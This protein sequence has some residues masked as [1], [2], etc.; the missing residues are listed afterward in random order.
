MS[1]RLST[2]RWSRA[3]AQGTVRAKEQLSTFRRLIACD[4]S[5]S[6]ILEFAFTMP[7]FVL[8]ALTALELVNLALAHMT[9]SQVAMSVADNL[10]R[11]KTS[12]P[13]GLPRLREV[14]IN[15]T[16]IGAGAQ[17]SEGFDLLKNGR[18]VVSSLQRN[19]SG[20]QTIAW[21]RC[22]GKL[23]VTSQYG[24]QGATQPNSGTAGFQGMGRASDRVQ[25]EP[26]S[27]IIFAEVTYDYQ[28]LIGSWLV[29]TFRLRKEAAFYVRDDR[30]LVGGT[31]ANGMYNP[32]PTATVSACNVFNDTF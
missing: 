23:A 1:K 9:A 21:Q 10:S 31:A 30:D 24:V 3:V 16:M 7:I 12:V 15:D 4:Q 2:A 27:A 18:I 20:R 17:G 6:V 29:G 13:L 32:S 8:L 26:N 25:A 5:G 11:A 22:K 14:D 19:A 28:P